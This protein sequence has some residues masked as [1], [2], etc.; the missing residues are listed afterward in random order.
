MINNSYNETMQCI[1]LSTEILEGGFKLSKETLTIL[2]NFMKLLKHSI[3]TNT[4]NKSGKVSSRTMNKISRDRQFLEI[5]N[6]PEI[7]KIFHKLAKKYGVPVCEISGIDKLMPGDFKNKKVTY[8]YPTQM[9]ATMEQIKRELIKYTTQLNSNNKNEESSKDDNII[10]TKVPLLETAKHLG[11]DNTTKEF[12]KAFLEQFPQERQF[13]NNIKKYK[14]LSENKKK[15][16]KSAIKDNSTRENDLDKDGYYTITVNKDKIIANDKI[17]NSLLVKT[18]DNENFHAISVPIDKIKL[19][20]NQTF[21]IR[22]K[23][24]DYLKVYDIRHKKFIEMQFK[25]LLKLQD[26]YKDIKFESKDIE[27]SPSI[28][29]VSKTEIAIDK[30]SII[31]D[32]KDGYLCKLNEDNHILINKKDSMKVNDGNKILTAIDQDKK[33]NI[34]NSKNEVIGTCLGKDILKYFNSVV[35]NFIKKKQSKPNKDKEN[36]NANI[37]NVKL[38]KKR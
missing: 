33:Y 4:L 38:R 29:N 13:Y 12:E 26:K 17:K 22:L 24:N 35:R 11:C 15:Q 23:L 27:K 5:E 31:K 8:T 6:N 18:D 32:L 14:S 7:K 3:D 1:K 37:K 21:N 25:D 36:K 19:N 10:Q 20:D 2:I 34:Y 16:I 28:D 30:T 9:T